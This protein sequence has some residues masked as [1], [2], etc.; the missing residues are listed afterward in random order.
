MYYNEKR[1]AITAKYVKTHLDDIKI[2][3]PK[4]Q[5]EKLKS[6][7]S[8]MGISMNQMFIKAVEEYIE[9]NYK[10]EQDNKTD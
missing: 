6:I 4:G 10:T 5:R 2:R 8:E 7:A 1:K 9:R 3:V